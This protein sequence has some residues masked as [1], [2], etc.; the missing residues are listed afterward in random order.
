VDALGI[1]TVDANSGGRLD[2]AVAGGTSGKVSVLLN[3]PRVA[4]PP[5]ITGTS[6]AGPSPQT[7]IFVKGTSETSQV[8]VFFGPNCNTPVIYG[9]DNFD[10]PGIQ[11][12]V[13]ANATTTITA[14]SEDGQGVSQ[15][16][17]PFT[18]TADSI[19]PAAPT[20]SATVPGSPSNDETPALQGS[21]EPGTTIEVYDDPSCTGNLLGSGPR[22]FLVAGA[23]ELSLPENTATD[24]HA[25]AIDGAGNE[26]GCSSPALTY[27]EDSVAPPE[28][29]GL[30]TNPLSPSGD[31]EPEVMGTAVA[32]TT[33]KVH[34]AAGC[35]GPVLASGGAAAFGSVGIPV[36]AQTDATTTFTATATDPAGN[37]SPCSTSSVDY[38]HSSSPPPPVPTSLAPG[39]IGNDNSPRVKGTA[40]LNS[41]VRL[42][43][44]D[45]CS[46]PALTAGSAASFAA[47]G[48]PVLV[49]DD[50]STSFW[51]TATNQL[52]ISSPCSAGSVTYVEDSNPA[53][54][55]LDR[56]AKKR[57]AR[58]AV[59]WFH[60][61][62]DGSSFQCSL[63]HDPFAEC[64]SP[65]RTGRLSPGRH[66]L[67]LRAVDRAGN[68]D[69]SPEAREFRIRRR[70]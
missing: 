30:A 8:N 13:P 20:L 26:S 68:V 5:V 51:A 37:S 58:K 60:S 57:K 41:V 12:N 33:V 40:Q 54:T 25:K 42:Y 32:G 7:S 70:R 47:P 66:E 1:D 59:A 18:Y 36:D 56:L 16:S 63:D 44:N 6:P 69:P 11:V 67:Q 10:D 65:H 48:L 38:Q 3:T 22:G 9:F 4:N 39:P 34:G 52:G 35:L 64:A 61:D 62:E 2:L 15:C 24:L 55:V 27:V 49:G 53:E 17:A 50:S 21:S 43:T 19:D 23:L 46:G 29:T 28:P 14:T 45:A 31:P